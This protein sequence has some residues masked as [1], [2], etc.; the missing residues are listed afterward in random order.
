VCYVGI[1]G[2]GG[3]WGERKRLEVQIILM[4]NIYHTFCKPLISWSVV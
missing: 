3:G 1:R 4:V 2:G